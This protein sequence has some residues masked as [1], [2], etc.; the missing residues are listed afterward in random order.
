MKFDIQLFGRTFDG[1]GGEDNELG[2]SPSA[3]NS[4]TNQYDSIVPGINQALQFGQDAMKVFKAVAGSPRL[5]QDTQG[6][7]NCYNETI[8]D[9]KN[10]NIKDKIYG[11]AGNGSIIDAIEIRNT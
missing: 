7:I 8:V 2:F 11:Y 9:G 1:E 3:F 10:Y 4:M 5:S 6:I